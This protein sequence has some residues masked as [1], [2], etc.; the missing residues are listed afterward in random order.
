[1]VVTVRY[2]GDDIRVRVEDDGRGAAEEDTAAGASTGSGIA[3]MAERAR[4]LGGE[5]TVGNAHEDGVREGGAGRG[6][7]V[8]ARLPLGGEE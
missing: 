7:R 6:F 5:L 1:M 8:E 4:A 3:G 2:E